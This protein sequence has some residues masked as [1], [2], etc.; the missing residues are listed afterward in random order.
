MLSDQGYVPVICSV[1]IGQDGKTYNI[2]ADHA[3][4]AV[5]AALG[6]SKLMILTDIE[7]LL[8]DK[9]DPNSLVSQIDTRA[10]LDMIAAGKAERGMIPKLEACVAAVQSGVER[11]HL[12]DGRQAHSMLV[13]IFTNSGVGTMIVP[14]APWKTTENFHLVGG[15][16]S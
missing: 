16:Q 15:F 8:E 7:G 9:D 2:N 10:A 1:A 4:G 13:E 14:P 11:A 3:A 5:A 12:I 6:A